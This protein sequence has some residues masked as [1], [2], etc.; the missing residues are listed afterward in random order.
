MTET[1]PLDGRSLTLEQFLAVARGGC[2]VSLDATA[3]AA[4]AASRRV[5]ERVV[6]A[7]RPVLRGHDRFRR[8]FP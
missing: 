4:V 6:A 8:A 7:N 3:R 1:L 2:G 5:V